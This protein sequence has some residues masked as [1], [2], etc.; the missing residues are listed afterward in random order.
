MG[1]HRTCKLRRRVG[2]T[3]QRGAGQ[4]A[5]KHLSQMNSPLDGG[6]QRNQGQARERKAASHCVKGGG[7]L[8]A[9]GCDLWSETPVC[10]MR[11]CV[12]QVNRA[13][14]VLEGTGIAFSFPP[15]QLPSFIMA[16]DSHS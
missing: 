13:H 9:P 3:T 14:G 7:D 5:N 2:S 11:R 1:M 10:N 16:N 4:P 12:L 8:R 6:C 15:S